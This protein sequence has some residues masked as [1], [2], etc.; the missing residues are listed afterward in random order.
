MPNDTIP[1]NVL[2][3]TPEVFLPRITH[4][5]LHHIVY[6]VPD[7]RNAPAFRQ[8]EYVIVDLRP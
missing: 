4:P 3:Q 2:G 7:E 5:S 6:A 1:Q 8:G